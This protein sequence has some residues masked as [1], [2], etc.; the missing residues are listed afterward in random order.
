MMIGLASAWRL[1]QRGWEVTV[2]DRM[3][4]RPRS[5]LGGR[6]MLAPGGEIDSDR[7]LAKMALRSLGMYPGFVR[8]LEEDSGLAVEY[9]KC[10]AVEVAFDELSQ[11]QALAEKSARQ[12]A[13]GI[14]SEPYRYGDRAGAPLSRRCHSGP[15]QH[16]RRAAGLMPP[17]WSRDSRTRTRDRSIG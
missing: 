14:A 9:R 12:A 1:A 17:A 7:A 6:G 13:M 10:G 8:D 4:S 15:A 3:G 5:Q 2:F 11:A 16:Q